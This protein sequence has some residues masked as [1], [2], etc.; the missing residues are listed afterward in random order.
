MF[1]LKNKIVLITGASAGIGEAC[2]KLLSGQGAKLILTARRIERLTQLKKSLNNSEVHCIQLDVSDATSVNDVIKNLPESWQAIDVLINNAGLA[3]GL[4]TVAE[5]N[6]EQF[7]AMIDT[8]IKGLLYMTRAIL[9]CMIERQ[10]GHIINLASIAGHVVYPKGV[11]YCATKHAVHAITQGLRQ[12][13]HGKNIRLTDI[14][15]GAVETE[16]SLVRLGDAEKAAKVYE[17][18]QPLTPNDIADTILYALT[19]PL[20]VNID[21]IILTPTAQLVATKIDFVRSIK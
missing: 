16:F 12:E 13:T 15:P 10:A 1:S 11:V 5:A 6:V 19:R 14:S 20:H 18:Y 4:E 9:P 7:D 2:A 3:A 21:E 17:G 8:N